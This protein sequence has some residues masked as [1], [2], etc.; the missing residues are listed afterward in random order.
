MSVTLEQAHILL[1]HNMDPAHFQQSLDS[2]RRWVWSHINTVQTVVNCSLQHA[3]HTV[4]VH[5]YVMQRRMLV[6]HC[7]HSMLYKL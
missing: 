2:M 1:E 4:V 6:L 5:G 7:M 3:T